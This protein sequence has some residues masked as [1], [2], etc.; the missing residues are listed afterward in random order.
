MTD[1][2]PYTIAALLLFQA[3]W[4][5]SSAL[6]GRTRERSLWGAVTAF[7]AAWIMRTD[8]GRY[9]VDGL[10]IIDL[11][12]LLKHSLAVVALCC[13]IRYVTAVDRYAAA[14]AT[15]PTRRVRITAAAHRYAP[16]AA[17]AVIGAMAL[18]FFT[19][20]DRSELPAERVDRQ[21]MIWHAGEAALA[22]YLVPF[23]GY[24]ILM[25][26]LAGY[27]WGSAARQAGRPALRAGLALMSLGMAVGIVYGIVRTVCSV[28]VAAL[29]VAHRTI[30]AQESVTD[31][32]L[33][34]CF[35]LWGI[36]VIAPT[37]QA[38]V[39]KYKT[40]RE[41]LR[42]HRLW[43][44]LAGVIP[45]L[46]LYPP[47]R[48]LAGNPLLAPLNTARDVFSREASSHVLLGR[49]VTEIRDAVHELRRRAPEELYQRARELA[50]AE[51][52]TGPDL[53]A[54]AE[55]YWIRAAMA[56]ASQ[57]P[58][59]PV[60]FPSARGES[61][62]EEVPWLLRVAAAYDQTDP[63]ATLGLLGAAESA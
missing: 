50:R 32:M 42:L 60:A 41:I 3:L 38:A 22:L 17:L 27:Q 7:A 28:W 8:L 30:N 37:S 24:Y 51:D 61:L 25:F 31:T 10:G 54:V 29:P 46:V 45:G 43:A 47:S 19:I 36:G 11:G 4:R 39:T 1:T 12:T 26:A 59:P 49:Y 2:V 55:A 34:T 48:I 14:S 23:Y 20:L 15:A 58:G 40:L 63:L 57:P 5:A 6:R 35:L 62:A 56:T 9:F 53:D 21:F 16:A 13:L 18:V 44:D 52:H 33:Y